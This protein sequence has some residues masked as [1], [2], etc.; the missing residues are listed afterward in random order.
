[1][2]WTQLGLCALIVLSGAGCTS[3]VKFDLPKVNWVEN[4][5]ASLNKFKAGDII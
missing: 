5:Q 3:F 4:Q 2:A 1:M